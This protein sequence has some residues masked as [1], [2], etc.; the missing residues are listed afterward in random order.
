M[1][2]FPTIVNAKTGSTFH[3]I[4]AT[5]S[6]II[7]SVRVWTERA[8]SKH[9][10]AIL[11]RVRVEQTEDAPQALDLPGLMSATFPNAKWAGKS[12]KHC[13]V[14]G[15]LNIDR[16]IWNADEILSTVAGNH[17]FENLYHF[18]KTTFAALY[19]SATEEEFVEFMTEQL[20]N[21]LMKGV[22]DN[23][24]EVPSVVLSFMGH[25]KTLQ[26]GNDVSP[27]PA[28][29]DEDEDEDEQESAGL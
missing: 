21:I 9:H 2:T 14:S 29:D 27:P 28:Q 20:T 18:I 10:T 12:S 13:S 22:S 25:K 16:P 6:G 23:L 3:I 1:K 8:Q 5:D 7:G 24:T 15:S 4:G 19:L 11:F 26:L 17:V